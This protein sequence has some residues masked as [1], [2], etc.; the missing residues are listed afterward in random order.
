M[1]NLTLLPSGSVK[2]IKVSVVARPGNKANIC[3][4]SCLQQYSISMDSRMI[5]CPHL[6]SGRRALFTASRSAYLRSSWQPTRMTGALGQKC[7]ISGYHMVLTWCSEFGLAIEK[8]STTTSDLQPIP[9]V[10]DVT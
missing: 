3:L 10:S 5:F 6:A 8:H 9:R 7:L 1:K 4:F 2:E